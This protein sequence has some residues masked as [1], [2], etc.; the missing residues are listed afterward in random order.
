MEKKY[1]ILI[2]LF[3]LIT[4]NAYSQRK[5]PNTEKGIIF[6]KGGSG[7]GFVLEEGN[8]F[9]IQLGGG[10]FFMQNLMAGA[11]LGYQKAG[12]FDDFY[13]RPFTRYYV[14]R[15]VF[16]GVGAS[17]TQLLGSKPKIYPDVEAGLALFLDSFIAIEPTAY[18]RV[19]D[20]FKP[21]FSLNITIFFSRF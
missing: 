18:Y 20:G 3:F 21:V 13:A 9:N 10:Y 5:K 4:F 15:R 1:F 8:P 16:A 7:G 2:F 19:Q 11:D 14:A 17:A 12:P 6:L